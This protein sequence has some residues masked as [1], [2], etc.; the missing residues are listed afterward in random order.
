MG[1]WMERTAVEGME[2]ASRA[3][4]ESSVPRD[5]MLQG[6]GAVEM[7]GV[8]CGFSELPDGRHRGR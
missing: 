6:G 1:G 3:W 5:Q 4:G 2:A 8:R 7:L